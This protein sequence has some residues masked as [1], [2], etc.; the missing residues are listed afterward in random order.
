MESRR[1][2]RERIIQETWRKLRD[3]DKPAIPSSVKCADQNYIGIDIDGVNSAICLQVNYTSWDLGFDSI[4]L[5]EQDFQWKDEALELDLSRLEERI[6]IEMPQE[7]KVIKI[8][9]DNGRTITFPF[10]TRVGLY[11]ADGGFYMHLEKQPLVFDNVE[12]R[13]EILMIGYEIKTL[14]VKTNQGTSK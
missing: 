8:K 1:E 6:S 13:V 7:T 5:E 9:L 4:R 11:T 10:K 3:T 12:F 14:Y 2:R